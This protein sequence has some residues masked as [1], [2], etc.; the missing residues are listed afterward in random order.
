MQKVFINNNSTEKSFS[1]NLSQI[2]N[3]KFRSHLRET[4]EL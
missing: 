3:I 1:K 2:P 4:S